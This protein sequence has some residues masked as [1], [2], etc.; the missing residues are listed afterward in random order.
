MRGESEEVEL[1]THHLDSNSRIFAVVSMILALFLLVL[2]LF[3]LQVISQ[4]NEWNQIQ[5]RVSYGWNTVTPKA[6]VISELR[7]HGFEI[8]EEEL[9]QG[10]VS[11]SHIAVKEYMFFGYPL[12]GTAFVHLKIESD[13]VTSAKTSI[14][15][16]S[17]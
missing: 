10:G 12:G 13:N 4:S 5:M 7:S 14:R 8:L 15:M 17:L 9:E 6:E 3:Q 1:K 2:V 16:N 11:Y